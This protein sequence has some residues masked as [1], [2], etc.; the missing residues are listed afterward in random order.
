MCEGH[1]IP[2]ATDYQ[3]EVQELLF[4]EDTITE[5]STTMLIRS[6][7]NIWNA[8]RATD[9]TLAD[10]GSLEFEQRR[11]AAYASS[12]VLL[13]SLSG[14]EVDGSSGGLAGIYLGLMAH[15]LDRKLPLTEYFI[16]ENSSAFAYEMQFVDT[17]LGREDW[18]WPMPASR[19]PRLKFEMPAIRRPNCAR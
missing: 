19:R 10:L 6:A 5:M 8:C 11:M 16:P 3:R 18:I 1:I 7:R 14:D 4:D 17:K 2:F 13:H 12:C 15:P 9:E